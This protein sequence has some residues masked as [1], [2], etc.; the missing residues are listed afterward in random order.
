L[1]GAWQ[2]TGPADL[3]PLLVKEELKHV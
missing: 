2:K 1:K 3:L